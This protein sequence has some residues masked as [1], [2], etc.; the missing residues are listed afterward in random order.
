MSKRKLIITIVAVLLV[1][2]A[3]ICCIPQYTRIDAVMDAAKIDKNGNLLGY[4]TVRIQSNRWDF[5]FFPSFFTLKVYDF[6]D[7]KSF[8]VTRHEAIE[9]TK[10]AST[11]DT[12]VKIKRKA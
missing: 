11:T 10:K 12:K 8:T 1:V 5:L 6:D 9:V 4:T 2:A 7:Y 3:L